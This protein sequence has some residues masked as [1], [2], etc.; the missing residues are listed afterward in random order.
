MLDYEQNFEKISNAKLALT[1]NK[2]VF[3]MDNLYRQL[4]VLKENMGIMEDYLKSYFEQKFKEQIIS[5]ETNIDKKQ[6]EFEVFKKEMVNISVQKISEEYNKALSDLKNK[7]I[8]MTETLENI[9][10]R[11]EEDITFNDIF[12]KE[13]EIE[14]KF[15]KLLNQERHKNEKLHK[16]IANLHTFYRL[17]LQMKK[18]KHT[19]AMNEMKQTLSSNQ[20]LWNKLSNTEKNEKILKEELARSQ[21]NLAS[22]EEFIKKLQSQIRKLHD[23]NV[24]LEKIRSNNST[25]KNMNSGGNIENGKMQELLNDTKQTQIYNL[26]DNLNLISAIE[27]TK[28]Q[29]KDEKD[30]KLILES[31]DLVHGKFMK[32]VENKRNYITMLNKIKEDVSQLKFQ[33]NAK[34][35]ELESRFI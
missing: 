31:F 14:S 12:Y 18:I 13:L 7:S 34:Y 10:K 19:N 3:E 15:T 2:M 21:K 17:K 28:H 26:K 35:K 25:M 8:F 11:R 6:A 23:K 1:G 16:T 24:E 32:E 4:K 27:R 20:D 22:S 29:Y 30:I 5:L 33:E 9:M